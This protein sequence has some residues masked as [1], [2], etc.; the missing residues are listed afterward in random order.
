MIILRKK[1]FHCYYLTQLKRVSYSNI[2][3]IYLLA[4]TM[5]EQ[6]EELLRSIKGEF[7]VI[8]VAGMYR[9]GKSY[10]LNQMLLNRSNGFSVGPTV[11]PCTKG[12]WI[13]NKPLLGLDSYSNSKIPILLIDTEGFGAFDED[14]NHD[15]KIFTLAVL[16]SSYFIY[17]SMGSIDENAIQSLSFVI[18]LS[19]SIQ[20]KG[21]HE[22]DPD[23]L[24]N[25]FPSFLWLVRD[26]SLQ[27]V[28]DDGDTITPKE[29]LEKV[30]DTS[31]STYDIDDKTKIRKLIKSYFKDRDCHTMVRPITDETKLQDLQNISSDKLRPDFVEGIIQL[32]KKVGN[33]IKPKTLNKKALN[34]EM[35]INMIKSFIEAIN[36]GAIPNIENTWSSM[37]KVESMKAF[38][39]AESAY[40]IYLRDNLGDTLSQGGSINS[41]EFIHG[42]H[43]VAKDNAIV[44]FK[45]K[46]LGDSSDEFLLKLKS[47]FKERLKHYEEQAEEGNRVE[48]YKKLKQF[49]SYF[50][51]KVYNPKSSDDE[52]TVEKIDDEL[53][54]MEGKINERFGDFKL[55]TEIFNEFKANVFYFIGEYL[56]KNNNLQIE[57]FKK[58]KEEGNKKLLEDVE[59][60]KANNLKEL[61]KKN[62]VIESYKTEVHELK[63]EISSTKHKLISLEKD[64]DILS[65]SSEEKMIRLKDDYERRFAELQ[66]TLI[67]QDEKVRDAERKVIQIENEKLREIALLE[68]NLQHKTKQID[69]FKKLEKESGVEMKSQLKEATNALKESTNK[70][71]LKIKQLTQMIDQL[72][73]DLVEADSNFKKSEAQLEN[74]KEKN[75]DLEKRI[76]A[77]KEESENK[78]NNAKKK[79]ETEKN[80]FLDEFNQKDKDSQLVIC[81]LKLQLE[82]MELKN[83]Q[84]EEELKNQLSSLQ[85]EHSLHLQQS[86]F[87]EEKNK[88][89]VSQIEEQ[90]RNHEA[91]VQKLESKT[92]SMIGNDEYQLKLD[93]IKSFYENERLQS[94][95]AF[96][97]Q[98]KLY[99]KQ[100][101]QLNEA[102]NEA[103]IRLRAENDEK[104]RKFNELQSRFDK[105][106]KDLKQI[107]AEKKLLSDNLN[108][109]HD[110]L[111]DKLKQML[112]AGDKKLEEKEY[113]H[114]REME[115]LTIKSEETIKQLKM[116]FETEKLRLEEKLK[117][118]KNKLD[119]KIKQLT[120]E[121]EDKI[122]ESTEE[123]QNEY[124]N[125][126]EE[127][128]ALEQRSLN[129]ESQAENEINLL[130]HKCETFEKSN[131]EMKDNLANI[132]INSKK[133][134]DQLLE[135]YEKDRKELNDKIESLNNLINSKD[136]EIILIKSEKERY[137]AI[138]KE[139]DEYV[140]KLRADVEEEKKELNQRI[141]EFNRKY[142]E[143]HDKFLT[144]KLE[145]A[146]EVAVL[147]QQ[148][149]FSKKK[150]EEL[151]EQLE[152]SQ[153]RY[154]E[155]LFSLRKEVEA[156][157]TERI[158]KLKIE[159]ENTEEKLMLK[160]KDL[161]EAEQSFVK[162]INTYEREIALLK[163]K[164]AISESQ[165]KE[166]QET[167]EKEVSSISALSK[168]LKGDHQKEVE[169]IIKNNEAQKSKIQNLTNE[170]QEAKTQIEKDNLLWDNKCKFL[171]HQRDTYKTD[172]NN[173]QA[174]FDTTIDSIQQKNSEEKERLE[175]NSTEKLANLEQKYTLQLKESSEKHA[176]IYS[177]LF[178][179]NKNYEK[180]L[181]NIKLE[182][183]IKNKSLESANNTRNVDELTE[184]LEKTKQE[185]EAIKKGTLSKTN[186]I[187][188]QM[189]KE[190][191]DLKKK[192]S[193]LEAKIKEMESKRSTSLFEIELEKG[194]WNNEKEHLL[195]N[196][197]E[198]KD[199]IET[200]QAKNESLTKDNLKL[201]NE[202]ATL[203]RNMKTNTSTTGNSRVG[204]GVSIGG[205]SGNPYANVV[206]GMGTNLLT[207]V[208]GNKFGFGADKIDKILDADVSG[209]QNTSMISNNLIGKNEGSSTKN[210]SLSNKFKF[211]SNNNDLED[212][213]NFLDK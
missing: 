169:D 136:K 14:Q 145:F 128:K 67:S 158:D 189:E 76:K 81:K 172:L 98:K 11:N 50:E 32:R 155:R 184:Q 181:K 42:V 92:F 176:N 4:F 126:E 95:E 164:L 163:E 72:R 127:Y 48:M 124:Y 36:K 134:L 193:E 115:E 198:L 40:E 100:I 168:N 162:Q 86:G 195:S 9:T 120:S 13:W 167:Y 160:K 209:I 7:A 63:E 3:L 131:K 96:E 143:G 80:K 88:E 2:N 170:L 185:L 1:L 116:I 190:K 123:L 60:L 77:E 194:K 84:F 130:T 212:D 64:N 47:L 41:S 19:K 140:F 113:E 104:E 132:T 83:K 34:G 208:I 196:I 15:I 90:K 122:K 58:E 5:S 152:Q 69:E 85:R 6:G 10:L 79:L 49:F 188:S 137:E 46:A 23:D 74:E 43:K 82:E 151:K 70:Y 101:D 27:L 20:L 157:Y 142:H 203:G 179:S 129:Y 112:K 138:I 175:K 146:K 56:K 102:K 117:E 119:R 148:L 89:L 33:K 210:E 205:R 201:K 118:E 93:E 68:Q 211:K 141:E 62:N 37:C 21:K 199:T 38:E 45:N 55:K 71:E 174:K 94:D 52:V 206:G 107:Q 17:N 177:E 150:A 39:S 108:E 171:E 111:N 154:E 114:H 166:L 105:T 61:K 173:L 26:F 133:E 213:S 24:S 178:N 200:I 25:L 12:L 44:I 103:E 197:N 18:N 16:L 78:I 159:K 202:K 207:G 30:L 97:S 139:K 91:I 144:D 156:D 180:E 65:K 59:E 121:Y 135:K 35:F 186:D 182:L 22:S 149:E 109:T 54:K 110:E 192:I 191:D 125:L 106:A 147:N 75:T 66:K 51:N 53:R 29:Y 161:K 8:S 165:R 28:D 87:L 183:E 31:K 204:G 99:V 73:E 57:Q 153:S 187:R